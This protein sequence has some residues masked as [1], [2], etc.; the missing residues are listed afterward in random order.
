MSKQIK[1]ELLE[2]NYWEHF[3]F[4]K[5]ISLVLPVNHPK[6]KLLEEEMNKMLKE[7]NHLKHES[8]SLQEG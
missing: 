5:D 7:I 4:A 6:R 8:S 2:Y 1:L 3:K